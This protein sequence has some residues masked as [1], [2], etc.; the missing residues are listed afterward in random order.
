MVT[1]ATIL[2]ADLDA[3]YASVE[4]LLDPSLRGKPIA[5]GG[6]VVLAASYEAKAFG[7][8]GGMSGRQAREL[9][10]QLMFV[11]GHFKD[12]QRLGDAAI[13][14]LGDFTPLVERISIDEA[15]ADV[16]GCTHLF[17]SPAEIAAAIRRRVRSELGLPISV[18]VARTKHLA[19]I[20]SQVAK[21]DGLVVVDPDSELK[22]LHGLPVELMW[23]V[24]PVTKARLAA[25]GVST[26]GQLAKSPETSLTRSLGPAAGEKLAALAW[27]RD[28]RELKPH[29]RAHSA[30]AQSA[31]GKRPAIERVIRPTL[32]HL[33]DRIAT[34]LRRKS[35]PGRTVTVRVRFA[36]M[37]AVTRS[38]TLDAPVDATL[39]LAQRA[40]KLVRAILA[41]HPGETVISLLAISVS[42]LEEHWDLALDLPLG[43]ADEALRPGSRLGS[44]R[45]AADC[46]VDKIRDRFGW[47]AIGYGSAVLGVSRS[48]PDAFRELAEK[49]L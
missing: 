48:V 47:D 15:F 45:W 26:I 25:M 13:G 28:P 44:A 4:Q 29:R 36:D 9:C 6:G 11:G 16:A 41:D 3:F 19:K 10:P 40:E 24:G 32:L 46:A 31:L 34:R 42:H 37:R 30:G 43:L 12:Y 18:G 49:E 22:F 38:I 39:I 8:R 1:A 23:G 33:A 27:N 5:V 7:V 20:A 35:R 17:G 14:V 21:P 2:H